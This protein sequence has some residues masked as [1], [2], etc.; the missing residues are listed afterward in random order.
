VNRAT[1]WLILLLVFA[2]C[3]SLPADAAKLR[4][5]E[6]KLE[7][8][9]I[10]DEQTNSVV[11]YTGWLVEPGD[12]FLTEDNKKYEVVRAEGNN[13]W[14]RYVQT[15]QLSAYLPQ[16][17]KSLWAELSSRLP[18]NLPVQQQQNRKIV[19]Y[20]SHSDESYIPSDGTESKAEGGGGIYKVG[21][22]MAKTLQ[23][24][25]IQ[26]TQSTANHNPH[27][28]NAYDRSRRTAMSLISQQKPDAIFDI[29][30]DAA[31]P[32]AYGTKVNGEN[33]T[34]V[35]LVVGKYNPQMKANEEFALKMKAAS[36]QKYPGLV[37]GIFYAKGGDYNQD[38]SPR[39]LLLEVGAHTNNRESAERGVSMLA[40]VVPAAVYGG[41]GGDGG[42]GAPAPVGA[43]GAAPA[44]VSGSTKAIGWI[45]GVVV[46][47]GLAFLLI[48]A[49]SMKDAGNKVSQ[50]WNTEFANLVGLKSRRKKKNNDPDKEDGT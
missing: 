15:I 36:D 8:S 24:Q 33:A 44:G 4:F 34:K 28:D 32:E 3:S 5:G 6:K 43:P 38:L 21:A 31:P 10:Y 19:I 13:A 22:A 23:S 14:A 45:V 30:R 48:S 7:W 49:G 11:W 35:Q 40:N 41:G 16:E 46:I 17:K 1:R 29:H 25:G 2:F 26:V 39:S 50:F 42:G 9:T 20:H 12:E 27:D 37:K 18:G 47:G